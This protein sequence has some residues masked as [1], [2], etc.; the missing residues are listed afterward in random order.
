MN[1]KALRVIAIIILIIILFILLGGICTISD[2][3]TIDEVQTNDAIDE[4]VSIQKR[5]SLD[6]GV[7][8]VHW[9]YALIDVKGGTVEDRAYNMVVLLNNVYDTKKSIEY[10]VTNELDH[11]SFDYEDEQLDYEAFKMVVYN[12]WDDTNGSRCYR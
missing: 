8:D 6:F 12:N 4:Y 1:N 2:N 10:Y 5:M 3:T 9:I 7:N 11:V